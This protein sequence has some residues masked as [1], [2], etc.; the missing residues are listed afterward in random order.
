[1]NPGEKNANRYAYRNAQPRPNTSHHPDRSIFC[2]ALLIIL[3]PL[4]EME[5]APSFAICW[6]LLR[7]KTAHVKKSAILH[8]H[9]LAR[10]FYVSSHESTTSR[11]VCLVE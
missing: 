11:C 1:M 3:F 6:I 10:S 5:A 9:T 4:W 7:Q 2:R 8:I